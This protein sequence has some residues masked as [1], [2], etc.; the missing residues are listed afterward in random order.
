MLARYTINKDF[1]KILA[2]L[3]NIMKTFGF[4]EK[5][6]VNFKWSLTQQDVKTNPKAP[7]GVHD[8]H[9]MNRVHL[10]NIASFASLAW[11]PDIK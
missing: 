6:S 1:I 5:K 9:K 7:H 8:Q 2:A 3:L 11:Y 10:W 4:S